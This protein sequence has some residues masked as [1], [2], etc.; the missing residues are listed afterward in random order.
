VRKG[1]IYLE[2]GLVVI[3]AVETFVWL[4]A[5]ASFDHDL[6]A[7]VWR[8]SGTEDQADDGG[9]GDDEDCELH[10]GGLQSVREVDFGRRGCWIE[11]ER[12]V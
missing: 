8:D 10:C 1:E 7:R 5:L 3:V 4:S 9:K 6:A 2:T 12:L 11:I